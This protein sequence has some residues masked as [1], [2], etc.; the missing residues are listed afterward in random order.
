MHVGRS[1]LVA[2]LSDHPAVV[3]NSKAQNKT[4][5]EDNNKCPFVCNSI[6]SA[7]C[8]H[9]FTSYYFLFAR[10][11]MGRLIYMNN[12]FDPSHSKCELIEVYNDFQG[13]NSRS[14]SSIWRERMRSM[15]STL[16]MCSAP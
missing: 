4:I 5:C 16:V 11:S 8:A 1:E 14:P 12:F 7:W 10:S 13:R 6:C 3:G 9:P 15:R 2:L